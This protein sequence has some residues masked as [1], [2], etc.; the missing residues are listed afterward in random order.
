MY[1]VA[2][3]L[4]GFGEATQTITALAANNSLAGAELAEIYVRAAQERL[5][6]VT[7]SFADAASKKLAAEYNEN[8][9]A[10]RKLKPEFCFLQYDEEEGKLYFKTRQVFKRS[11]FFSGG[12]TR[13]EAAAEISFSTS[14][15]ATESP[16][17]TTI[18]L[19]T[20]DVVMEGGVP[21]IA[22]RTPV[23]LDLDEAEPEADSTREAGAAGAG[24]FSFE[25]PLRRKR[26]AT[27]EAFKA[28]EEEFTGTAAGEPSTEAGLRR[29]GSSLKHNRVEALKR[30]EQV[31][32][33][34]RR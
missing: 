26:E 17:H 28:A 32:P 30:G 24:N 31:P 29:D 2:S 3:S 4:V 25:N 27:H 9:S 19:Q 34:P 8:P 23:L 13:E 1:F 11:G 7:Q 10:K 21:N 14:L 33:P 18:I 20:F 15:D 16:G 6:V 12:A 5:L 22:R